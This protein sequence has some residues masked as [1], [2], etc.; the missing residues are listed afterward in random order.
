M[1]GATPIRRADDGTALDESSLSQF[2][3][4]DVG[5]TA[6]NASAP[7]ASPSPRNISKAHLEML[8]K[9]PSLAPKFDEVYG[10][11]AS[12]AKIREA[13][14]PVA[15][16]SSGAADRQRNSAPQR[17]WSCSG[18]TLLNATTDTQCA[19][20]N[21]PRYSI[22]QGAAA[23]VQNH[24]VSNG[25]ATYEEED[26]EEEEDATT[27]VDA[28]LQTSADTVIIGAGPVGLFLAIQLKACCPQMSVVVFEKYNEYQRKHVLN[29]E[30][31]SLRPAVSIEVTP[32]A[33]SFSLH[34]VVGRR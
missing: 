6:N 27:T 2:Q 12:A 33:C 18:C 17:E 14:S 3:P 5:Y 15:A 11:G 22:G 19:L 4:T 21:T 28:A 16:F 23:A 10:P 31:A 32:Y 8:L 9:D 13:N 24:A 26:E 20:C 30:A 1:R 25:G 34:G 7:T 29:I